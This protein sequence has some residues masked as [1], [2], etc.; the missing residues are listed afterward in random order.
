MSGGAFDYAWWPIADFAEDLKAKI[1]ENPNEFN[2]L[3]MARLT[4]LQMKAAELA[5]LVKAAELLYSG[6]Y[7][8]DSFNEAW[9]E[10]IEK[11]RT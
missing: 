7:G 1:E 8:E 6:D 10:A 2:P 4:L 9:T 3:L 11:D 5:E